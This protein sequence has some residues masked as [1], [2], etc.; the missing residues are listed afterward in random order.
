MFSIIKERRGKIQDIF[1]N[2]PKLISRYFC[3][4]REN[5]HSF[6]GSRFYL[7]VN[8]STSP[9]A[10]LLVP[11]FL[12]LSLSPPDPSPTPAPPPA[13]GELCNNERKR[14]TINF[15]IQ[16]PMKCLPPIHFVSLRLFANRHRFRV[17]AALMRKIQSVYPS[18][19][20]TDLILKV[21]GNQN[22][23][24]SKSRGCRF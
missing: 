2:I 6:L 13:L 14:P 1:S 22:P 21:S 8:L 18:S 5:F 19:G 24:S 10:L 16:L 12:S 4:T 11:S 9:L 7:L 15:D 23:F 20:N 3:S 17:F